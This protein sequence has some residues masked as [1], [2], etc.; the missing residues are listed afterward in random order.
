MDLK[1]REGND[2]YYKSHDAARYMGFSTT[3]LHDLVKRKLLKCA[4]L[5]PR[6]AL[7]KKSHLDA[8]FDAN[9]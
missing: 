4:W 3:Y 7:F 9:S 2:G 6:M 5:S 8:L 1:F